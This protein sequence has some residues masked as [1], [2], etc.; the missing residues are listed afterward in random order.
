MCVCV[1]VQ[2]TSVLPLASL[3]GAKKALLRVQVVPCVLPKLTPAECLG[4]L[5]TC[6]P[7]QTRLTL[8]Q[9][10][11]TRTLNAA[12]LQVRHAHTHTHVPQGLHSRT[13]WHGVSTCCVM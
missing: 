1:C 4:Y 2:V 12:E 13:N 6:L 10:I 5:A 8:F 11:Y 9:D 7:E 3:L